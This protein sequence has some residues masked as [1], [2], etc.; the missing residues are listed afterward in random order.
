MTKLWDGLRNY[1]ADVDGA[2]ARFL[3]DEVLYGACFSAFLADE[4]F[5]A[6]GKAL[7]TGDYAAA[8]DCAHTLKGVTGNMGLTPLYEVLCTA[9]ET[10]RQGGTQ[11]LDENYQEICRQLELLR[12]L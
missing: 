1:G 8:F 11:G 10:M 4:A 9:V 2:M 5:P 7:A 12:Q 3:D 6:L